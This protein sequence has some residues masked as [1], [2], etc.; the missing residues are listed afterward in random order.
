MAKG[1]TTAQ[2]YNMVGNPYP[3][4]VDIG[5]VVFN[6][7]AAGRINGSSFYIWNPFLGA[8]GQF[9]AIPYATV[10]GTPVA[11][12][13]YLQT[14]DAFQVR[15]ANNGDLLNFTEANKS[16]NVTSGYSLMKS[17]N[18]FVS[19][20]VYDANYHPYDML[21]VRFDE[22]A[23]GNEDSKFDAGKP[24]GS[25]FNFYSLSADNHKLAI[26]ARP[27]KVED[28]IPL[29]MNSN[30]AQEYIIRAENIAV[31]EGGMVY[32]HDKFLQQYTLLQQGTEYRFS[33]TADKMTQGENRF[34]LTM[35]P[36]AVVEAKNNMGLKVTMSPNP[37]VDEVKI[38]LSQSQ[39]EN[40]S[41][42]LVD[43]AGVSVFSKDLGAKLN[44]T[45]SVPLSNLAA[46][47]YM[48]EVA[49]GSQKIVQTLVKE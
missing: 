9:Q 37:A 27:Y 6:A 26:D 7:A 17:R 25:E 43:M 42:N 1:A 28:V 10:G 33:I 32:L 14:N 30:Y 29:G 47:M 20:Y 48:V 34:E 36:A 8:A 16:A 24:S 38:S 49:S 5:T 18:E 39:K 2:D 13:Y 46:G 3:S 35:A 23:T 21:Y 12:P 40:V 31:P 22:G 44:A 11:V 19:L 15:A 4:P 45:V 41:I